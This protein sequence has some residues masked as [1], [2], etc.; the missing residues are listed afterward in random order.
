MDT[1]ELDTMVSKLRSAQD[2]LSN[3]ND[4]HAIG[5]TNGLEL[6]IALL[7]NNEPHFK[8]YD[9]SLTKLD[10]IYGSYGGGI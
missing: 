6:A 3:C 2:S 5:M 1:N 4:E 9:S 10:V 7:T 8:F